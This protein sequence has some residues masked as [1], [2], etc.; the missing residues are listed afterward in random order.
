[1]KVFITGASGFIG[2]NLTVRLKERG[3]LQL[4]FYN[5]EDAHRSLGQLLEDVDCIFHLSGVNRPVNERDFKVHNSE[6]TRDLCEAVRRVT[7]KTLKPIKIIFASSTQATQN[8][9]YGVSKRLSEE[10]LKQINDNS[11]VNVYSF[12]L[13]NVFGKWSRPNYNSVV[14]TFCHNIARNIPITIHDPDAVVRLTYI[15]DVIEGFFNV[16]DNNGPSL[17]KHSYNKIEPIYTST[18]GELAQQILKFKGSRESLLTERVG[19]DLA[20]A[21]YATYVSFLPVELV[22]Y[23]IPAY[24]DA[25]GSFIEMMKT[26]DCGQFSV[27]TAPP[28]VT[29]GGHYHHTK[30]E[31]FLVVKGFAQFRF[32]NIIDQQTYQIE[33]SADEHKVVETLPGWAHDITNIGED[34]IVVILWANEVFNKDRPD[35]FKSH[36]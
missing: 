26:P 36:T 9:A 33:V 13:N 18:V 24:A 11:L 14:A 15:D 10:Y 7:K 12:R 16:M 22:G 35:T 30:T 29:R 27:F 3:D 4:V 31:K 32:R 21:L 23:E 8:T 5:R 20:R 1:M 19:T 6:F 25:R 17:D 2:K 28:G 34:E